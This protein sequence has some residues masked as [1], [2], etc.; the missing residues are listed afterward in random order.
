VLVGGDG[1]DTIYAADGER[2]IV[3][4]GDG[5]DRAVVDSVDVVKNCELVQS[6]SAPTPGSGSGSG[7]TSP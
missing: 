6:G 1:S 4:C 5:N 2:D 3:D 7:T